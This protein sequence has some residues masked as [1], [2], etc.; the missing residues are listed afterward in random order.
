MTASSGP[1]DRALLSFTMMLFKSKSIQKYLPKRD[2]LP[3]IQFVMSEPHVT[4]GGETTAEKIMTAKIV[5][6]AL[7]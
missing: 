7:K 6:I 1:M 2:M 5:V 4:T 3:N